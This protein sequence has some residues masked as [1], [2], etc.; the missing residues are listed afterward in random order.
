MP[1][2]RFPDALCVSGF[3]AGPVYALFQFCQS[4]FEV[5]IVT[6]RAHPTIRALDSL[7][8][9]GRKEHELVRITCGSAHAN[10]PSPGGLPANPPDPPIR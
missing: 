10:F 1:H 5:A 4:Y 8:P 7:D 9:P 2:V 3:S 6:L